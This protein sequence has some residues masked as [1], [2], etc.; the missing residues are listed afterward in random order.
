MSHH[1]LSSL[2]LVLVS[3]SCVAGC[4]PTSLSVRGQQAHVVGKI[5]ARLTEQ[6]LPVDQA[7]PRTD[8]VR[9]RI[10]CFK[11]DQF[12]GV[13]WPT[14]FG[15]DSRGLRLF[16]VEGDE[17][18]QKRVQSECRY[19]FRI[20]VETRSNRS[21]TD[22]KVGSEWWKLS[23]KSCNVVSQATGQLGCTYDYLST[24]PPY[25]PHRFVYGILGNL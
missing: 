9:T 6:G 10:V 22:V 3:L 20:V 15:L 21:N 4:T 11:L 2:G 12:R 1:F 16:V 5:K 25:D 24:M 23:L 17:A 14:A 19:Q 13:Q 7:Y 8:R 18:D